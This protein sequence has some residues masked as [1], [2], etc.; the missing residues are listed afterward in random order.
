ME[1]YSDITPIGVGGDDGESVKAYVLIYR[2]PDICPD[3]E[4]YESQTKQ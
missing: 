3:W 1:Q 4:L 2:T